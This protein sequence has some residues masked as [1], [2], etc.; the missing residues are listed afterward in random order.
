MLG[1]N[2]QRRGEFQ[3]KTLTRRARLTQA[4]SGR[5]EQKP[6]SYIAVVK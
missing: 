2:C 6:G 1:S 4:F 5:L 3:L